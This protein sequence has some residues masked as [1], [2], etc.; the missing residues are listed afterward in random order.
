[1]DG[2]EASDSA[3]QEIHDAQDRRFWGLC[4]PNAQI[5]AENFALVQADKVVGQAKGSWVPNDFK[6]EGN[7]CKWGPLAIQQRYEHCMSRPRGS[8]A[9]LAY[10]ATYPD[11]FLACRD[12]DYHQSMAVNGPKECDEQRKY[13]TDRVLFNACEKTNFSFTVEEERE[14]FNIVN[15]RWDGTVT[16]TI[17]MVHPC[18]SVKDIYA[19]YNYQIIEKN[20]A[21]LASWY[22]PKLQESKM[23]FLSP[24][25]SSMRYSYFNAGAIIGA[26]EVYLN[27]KSQNISFAEKF[28]SYFPTNIP[29]IPKYGGGIGGSPS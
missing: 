24:M 28:L 18:A 25:I 4:P 8:Q 5:V 20:S 11:D 12:M 22:N 3:K 21:E 16:K 23:D 26:W 10:C 7:D 1:M 13:D 19:N 2:S 17:K 6:L 27:A 14:K 9:L 29:L 15:G